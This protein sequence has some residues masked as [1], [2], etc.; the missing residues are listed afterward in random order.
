[1]IRFQSKTPMAF[2]FLLAFLALTTVLF[3]VFIIIGRLDILSS[4]ICI[5][6]SNALAFY[7]FGR[8]LCIFKLLDNKI[9]LTFIY[10]IKWTK[11]YVFNNISEID[12]RGD[13]V[14][15]PLGLLIPGMHS[16]LSRGFYRLYLTDNDGRLL[17]I[18]Y[19]ISETDNDKLIR[20]LKKQVL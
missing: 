12:N 19:N 9:S 11:E 1:M 17:D 6:F 20:I 4:V 16:S 10:P 7:L 13:S 18:K 14:S 15:S 3:L 2:Y 8:Y 5:I